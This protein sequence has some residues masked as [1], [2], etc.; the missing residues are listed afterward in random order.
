M[1]VEISS[2]HRQKIHLVFDLVDF[3]VSHI[4]DVQGREIVLWEY[5]TI[6]LPDLEDALVEIADAFIFI[7]MSLWPLIK[8]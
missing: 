2:D 7:I 8:V 5:F 1:L 3:L 6:M 4:F